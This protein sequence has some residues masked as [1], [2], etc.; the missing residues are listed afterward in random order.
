MTGC[1]GGAGGGIKHEVAIFVQ[2]TQNRAV[3]QD[4]MQSYVWP[5]FAELL[6]L[7]GG[8]RIVIYSI[9]ANTVSS[10][11]LYSVAVRPGLDGKNDRARAI[12]SFKTTL[13]T[14]LDQIYQPGQSQLVDILG[15]VFVLDRMLDA[16][17]EPKMFGGSPRKSRRS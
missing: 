9:I 7:D 14:A 16:R 17:P 6:T 10:S 3:N 15:S 4:I 5:V 2:A 8:V 1:G 12:R 11:A 13:R